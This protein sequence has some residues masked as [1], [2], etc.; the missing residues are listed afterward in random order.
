MPDATLETGVATATP[1][2]QPQV[3]AEE[4]A[5]LAVSA[6]D[7]S[8]LEERV[9]RTVDVVRREREARSAAEGRAAELERRATQAEAKHAELE[10]RAAQ[11]EARH[12]ELETRATQAEAKHAELESRAAQAEAKVQEQLPKV[13]QLESELKALHTEREQVKLR[14]DKLLK[15]LDA[16]EL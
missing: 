1:A 3:A 11:A 14:V 8:A 15:Q 12:A 16:L 5:A 10:S 7:F 4:P 9:R 2:A 6:D 13:G